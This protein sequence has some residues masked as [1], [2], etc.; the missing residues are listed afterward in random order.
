MPWQSKCQALIGQYIQPP[1][2][3]LKEI[4]GF[5][6]LPELKHAALTST[7]RLSCTFAGY[8]IVFLE[9]IFESCQ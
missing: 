8:A 7:N 6:S 1:N 4:E 3:A 5:T 9:R 2:H